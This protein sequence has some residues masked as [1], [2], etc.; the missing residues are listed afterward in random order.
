M[1]LH[2]QIVT[3]TTLYTL[4]AATEMNV[5]AKYDDY[6]YVIRKDKMSSSN[7]DLLSQITTS[8]ALTSAHLPRLAS[9]SV[10]HDSRFVGERPG[11]KV[12]RWA[13]KCKV[14]QLARGE[15]YRLH[16]YGRRY[17]IYIMSSFGFLMM[18]TTLSIPF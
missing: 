2:L 7:N 9:Q 18:Y 5:D 14:L 11:K 8:L 17:S 10:N 12:S 4:Q 3:L 13:I 1:F 6:V 16:T 15:I